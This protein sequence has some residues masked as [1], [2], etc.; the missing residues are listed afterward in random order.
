[1][2]AKPVFQ[3]I[4]KHLLPCLT[5]ILL[6]T[7]PGRANSAPPA[8]QPPSAISA[9]S[10]LTT[11]R[12][13]MSKITLASPYDTVLLLLD[14]QDGGGSLRDVSAQTTFH[15]DNPRVVIVTDNGVAEWRGPGQANVIA[16]VKAAGI[17]RTCRIPVTAG[18]I[19]T[20]KTNAPRFL[21]DFMPILTKAGCNMG[22][23]HGANAGRGGFDLSLLG[24]EPDGDYLALTRFVGARRISPAQPDNSLILRKATA[25]MPHG[26]GARFAPDSAAYRTLRDWIAA[27]APRPVGEGAGAE[28]RVTRLVVTPAVRTLQA[29]ETQRL[30]VEAV[31]ED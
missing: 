13:Q 11:L 31:Y 12:P 8:N 17:T 6:V 15:S 19:R 24:Y 30:R 18:A 25:R 26:G 9:P 14:G 4:V 23:C 27:G 7:G 5:A 10:R 20:A 16:T 2:D 28:P 3:N 1:M 29:G 21:T 22:A